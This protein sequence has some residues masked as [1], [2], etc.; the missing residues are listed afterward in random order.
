MMA[1]HLLPSY[2][3]TGVLLYIVSNPVAVG[4]QVA[5]RRREVQLFQIVA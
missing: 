4:F 2:P 3:L 5:G 1:A